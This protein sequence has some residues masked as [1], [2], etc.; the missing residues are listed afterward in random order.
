MANEEH[1]KIIRQGVAAWKDWREKNP[2]VRPDLS[3]ADLSAANLSG[4]NLVRTNLCNTTLT[5]SRVYGASAWDIEVDDQTKQQNLVITPAGAAAIT[6][7]DIEVAQFIYLLLNNQKIRKVI[8]TITS[9]AVLILGRFSE[10]R[11]LIPDAIRDELRNRDYLPIM[12]DF[13]PSANQATIETIKTLA[14]MSRFVIA[15][16]TDVRSVLMELAA[17]VPA[18][19]SVAVRLLIK[20]SEHEYFMLDFIRKYKSVVEN[21]Y[22][23]ENLEE[24]IA[25]IKENIIE[26]AEAKVKE[27]LQRD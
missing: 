8:D 18:Y 7:D 19:P 20:K 14:S 15:D 1:L 5:G 4:A 27:L 12:F 26:P 17:I 6:V 13:Q 10:E 2:E 25:S 9:K 24:V 23:Y 16:L 11:K 22:Q 21:T 3:Y